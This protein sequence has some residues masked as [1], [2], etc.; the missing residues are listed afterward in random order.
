LTYQEWYEAHYQKHKTIM[1]KLESLSEDEVIE[2][3]DYEN[4]QQNEPDFCLLYQENKKCH[5]MQD[6]NCYLCA[7]PEFRVQENLHVKSTCSI[8]SKFGKIFQAREE[9]HQDCSDCLVPHKKKYIRK[10]FSRDWKEIMQN[11]FKLK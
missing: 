10:N 6:L 5:D 8:N 9:I 1:K 11:T 2:Y 4:M 3:F 7:C